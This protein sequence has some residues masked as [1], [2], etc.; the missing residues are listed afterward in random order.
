MNKLQGTAAVLL[1]SMLAAHAA[2]AAAGEHAG[3][4]DA[5]GLR[6][7]I[8]ET[9]RGDAALAD[10]CFVDGATGWAVGDRGA[11]WHTSDSGRTWQSQDSHTSCRLNSVCFLDSRRGWAVG[12]TMRP[13][14][15]ASHGVVLR[16][17]DGG[18]TWTEVPK[19][20]LPMLTRVQ[21]FDAEQGVAMGA[22]SSTAPGGVFHT[23][24]GGQ[25]WRPLPTDGSGDW[26]AGDFV[27]P[28]AGAVAGPAGRLATV[29]QQCVAVSPQVNAA[30]RSARALRLIAPTGGWLVGDGGLVMTTRDL[31]HSWQSPPAELPESVTDNFDFHAVAVEGTHVWIAGAPGTRVFH[32]ADS[33]RTWQSFATGQMV[34]LRALAFA[35]ERTGWAVGDLGTILATQ[36]GGR[37]WQVQHAGGRRAALVALFGRAADV[38]L[39]MIAQYGAAEGYLTAVDVLHPSDAGAAPSRFLAGEC[40]RAAMIAAGATVAQTAWQFPLPPTDLA[41][42]PD[43]LLAALNRA[44]DGRAIERL[45]AHVVREIRT[46]RPEVVVTYHP[47]YA[48][49]D[50]VAALSQELIYQAIEAAAD[51]TQYVELTTDVGLEPWRVKRV[52]GL[53]PTGLRG[54]QSIVTNEFSPRLGR[55]LADWAAP[56]RHLLRAPHT[57]PDAYTFQLVTE[58]DIASTGRRDFFTGSALSPGCEARRPWVPLPES[59]L[60]ALR[61]MAQKRRN[62]QELLERTEAGTRHSVLPGVGSAAWAGQVTHLVDGLDATSGGELLFQ[63]AA[64]Y[65]AGGQL[66]L[67]ADTYYLLTRRCPNHPLADRALVWLVQFYASSEAAINCQPSVPDSRPGQSR[68]SA[69]NNPVQQASATVPLVPAAPPAVSLSRDDRLR[70]AVQLGEYLAKARPALFAEPSVRFPLVTAQRQLGYA[71]PAQ[72]YFLALRGLPEDD[73]WRRCAET[74]LWFAEPGDRPPPK[75]LG[76]CR[77]TAQRPHLDGQLDEPLWESADAL[78]LTSQPT[79]EVRLSYD[80]AFLYVAVR[81]P[82]ASG[83]D[84]TADDRP[85]DRDSDLSQRDRVAVRIDVDRDFTTSFELVVDDRGWPRDSCAGDA[86]WNPK[87]FIAASS[88]QESWTVEIAVPLAELVA[89]PPTARHVWAVAVQRTIPKTGHQSW[90]GDEAAAGNSPGDTPDG[91]PDQF[92]MV[93]FD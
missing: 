60:D 74:E 28:G 2:L 13:A 70:R 84:Y 61:R 11:V 72:R 4:V 1:A 38:P 20:I 52:F 48:E 59:D 5:D 87:W 18:A 10:V 63:L 34:P 69:D 58:E 85:R 53:M 40:N 62:M 30:S 42:A 71:N 27:G 31:G 64:G 57:P 8:D 3:T 41:L 15:H 6:R 12:G 35:D 81:C 65:E 92:G 90:S 91:T 56:S 46:W 24:D 66:D 9:M 33:G 76:I 36:D 47:D 89:E 17:R 43:E 39:E 14:A 44:Q 73:A 93:L 21:F 19:L 22:G 26:L 67:A 77:R 29:V 55:T 32:S 51:P 16:T 83:V 79:P 80:D 88:D 54:E 37:S 78:R 50:P 23:M 7:A 86:H 25:T 68:E 45:S 82:K 75:A 49:T